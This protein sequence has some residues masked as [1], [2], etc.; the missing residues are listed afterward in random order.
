MQDVGYQRWRNNNWD[1]VVLIRFNIK[2]ISKRMKNIYY[3][4]EFIKGGVIKFWIN[5]MT[6]T[7]LQTKD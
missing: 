3:Y 7:S 4:I 1:E 6:N 5:I 2:K